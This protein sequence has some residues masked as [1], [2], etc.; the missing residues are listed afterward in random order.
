[1]RILLDA[2]HGGG[3]PGAVR[4]MEKDI[5][6]DVVLTLG[7]KL[8]LYGHTV[9]YT[10]SGDSYLSPSRR[11][12]L[13][14]EYKPDCFLSIHCNASENPK[15]HGAE[16]IWR[17]Q[18]DEDLA[19]NI[20]TS[21]VKFTGLYNRGLKQDGHKEYFRNLAVLKDLTTPACLIEIGFISNEDDLKVIHDIQLVA[22]AIEDGIANWAWNKAKTNEG[23]C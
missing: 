13:I 12:Q 10:R 23:R 21:L 9:R 18:Y 16:T 17:D 11:L 5:T 22:V 3:D 20:Q 15:A 19:R 2:G 14:H 4:V 7:E 6:L 8:S 1:M